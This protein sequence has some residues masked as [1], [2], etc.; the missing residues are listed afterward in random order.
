M[1]QTPYI[2]DFID[3]AYAMAVRENRFLLAY[4]LDMARIEARNPPTEMVV[5]RQMVSAETRS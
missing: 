4:L 3:I 5:G 1:T 2:T